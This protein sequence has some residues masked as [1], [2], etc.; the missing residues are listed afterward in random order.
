[1]SLKKELVEI[2]HKVYSK[3]FVAAYDGNLS[4]R[5]PENTFLITRSA[6]CKGDV[7]EDDIIEIDSSGNVING[8]AKISTENKIHLFIYNNRNDI[9]AV[10]HGHPVYATAIASSKNILDRPVFPEVILTIGRIPLCKYATPSTEGL[11]ESMKPFINFA[12]VFLLQN[13]GAVVAGKNIDHAYYLMEKLEHTAKTLINTEILGGA[14]L[15]A[16]EKLE[17]LYSIAESTYGLEIKNENKFV[18]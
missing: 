7:T 11:T 14:N 6:I 17:E 15:I 5:T 12:S 10:I 1:M 3:G 2:C 13:H 16:S 9:N 18:D 8:T 4:L